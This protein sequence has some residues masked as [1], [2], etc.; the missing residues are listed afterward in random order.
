MLAKKEREKNQHEASITRYN[1]SMPRNRLENHTV[2]RE[3][4]DAFK[5]FETRL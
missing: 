4:L 2:V 5:F 1:L 3:A